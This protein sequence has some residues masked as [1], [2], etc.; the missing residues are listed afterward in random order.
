DVRHDGAV[1]AEAGADMKDARTGRQRERID[2]RRERGRV[3]VEQPAL[4]IDG[5]ADVVIDVPR[6]RVG[7]LARGRRQ[8]GRVVAQ[9]QHVPRPAQQEPLAFDGRERVGEPRRAEG[10]DRVE[11]LGVEAALLDQ[12]DAAHRALRFVDRSVRARRRVRR[13]GAGSSVARAAACSAAF[14][15]IA[16]RMSLVS[17][18]GVTIRFHVYWCLPPGRGT[19]RTSPPSFSRLRMVWTAASSLA[20]FDMSKPMPTRR[21]RTSVGVIG[22]P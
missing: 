3:P 2:P 22:T 20:Y 6:I 8:A 7:R 1:V 9:A 21:S 10:A 13:G 18:T 14:S 15:C 17:T 4:D 19:N 16:W 12:I 5:N 11:L